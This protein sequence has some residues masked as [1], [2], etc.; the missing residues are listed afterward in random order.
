M[1]D[2]LSSPTVNMSWMRPVYVVIA[3]VAL[4]LGFA[5][6]GLACGDDE[7]GSGGSGTATVSESASTT[8]T[9]AQQGD[10][11]APEDGADEGTELAPESADDPRPEAPDDVIG[12]RPGAG[13]DEDSGP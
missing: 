6:G 9:E 5:V 11:T 12:E 2:G 13:G 8:E 4:A 10:V 3:V 1:C 7:N